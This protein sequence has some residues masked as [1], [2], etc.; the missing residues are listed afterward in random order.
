M[1]ER[2]LKKF[3]QTKYSFTFDSG[4]SALYFA[5]KALGVRENDEVLVQSFTCIVVINAIKWL[6]AIPIYVDV[7][8][9]FN[10]NPIDLSEKIS[11]KSKVLII[12]HTFGCPA[13]LENILKIAKNNNLK[14]IEDCAHAFGAKSNGRLTGTFGDVG[15]FS[16]GSD[17]VLSC[18]R[19]GAL[20]T[21][22]DNIANVLKSYQDN[23]PLSPRI[24][25]IQHLL[26]YLFF[27]IGK[28]IYHFGVGKWLLA[29]VKNLHII[30]RIVYPEEKLGL[31]VLFYPAKFPNAL[32][33][34]LLDKFENLYQIIEHQKDIALLFNQRISNP[35]ITKP[36]WTNDSIWLRYTILVDEPSKLHKIAKIQNII[37]GNWYDSPVVASSIDLSLLDYKTGS[38]PND[39]SISRRCL[40]LPTDINISPADVDKIVKIVNSY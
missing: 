19:G 8:D 5:L 13:D 28:P 17:K 27:W 40:N 25:V 1:V 10:M 36:Y 39:E 29:I 18:V 4:R 7:K 26:N 11:S 35:N 34:I 3:F 2:W 15:M 24:K 23:L 20:V 37:L 31:P 14:I 22:D 32:A 30:N 9:D 12:Q 6:G 33:T 21:N 38:C 16:F